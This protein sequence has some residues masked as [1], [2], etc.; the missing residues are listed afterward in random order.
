MARERAPAHQHAPGKRVERVRI[1]RMRAYPVEQHGQPVG[2]RVR[3]DR[4]LRVLRLSALAMRRYHEPP[5][6]LVG[7][8]AAVALAQYMQAAIQPGGSAGRGQYV[9][10]VHMEH[11]RVEPHLRKAAGERVGPCPGRGGG[12]PVEQRG[13]RRLVDIAPAWNDERDVAW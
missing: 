10:V 4:L 12:A 7:G 2:A 11:I 5:R 9:A 3:G 1:V 8:M 13:G 6:G